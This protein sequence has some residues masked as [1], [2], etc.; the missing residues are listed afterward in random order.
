MKDDDSRATFED[1]YK[2]LEYIS[3][4]SEESGRIE[5]KIVSKAQVEREKRI[6]RLYDEE[7]WDYGCYKG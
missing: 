5:V 6:A 4:L 1:K 2:A 3:K 7:N